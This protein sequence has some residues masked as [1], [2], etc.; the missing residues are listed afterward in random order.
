MY[1][2]SPEK[3]ITVWD[4]KGELIIK[5]NNQEFFLGKMHRV[6]PEV[7]LFTYDHTI[8]NSIQLEIEAEAIRIEAIENIRLGNEL[9]FVLRI[10]ALANAA[11]SK[12]IEVVDSELH[13]HVNQSKW[14]E[15]LRNMGYCRIILL[16]IP[17]FNEEISP[18][19]PEAVEHLKNA[20]KHMLNGHFRDS[21][22]A[23]RDVLEAVSMAL[24]DDSGQMPETIESWFQGQRDMSKEERLRLV[25][26]A[27]KVVTHPARHADEV[28]SQI[29]WSPED[30]KAVIT[31]T[32]AILQLTTKGK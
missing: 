27:L 15:I 17:V 20:Q 26:R 28:A 5:K 9:E 7:Q 4:I 16:E 24:K 12:R 8:S 1:N 3:T 19:F 30:A 2:R 6:S 31:M 11:D 21:V 29:E 23:C 10:Y 14:V 18:L 22:G 13:Y 32:A 25:R